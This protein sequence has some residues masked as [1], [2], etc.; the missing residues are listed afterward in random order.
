MFKDGEVGGIAGGCICWEVLLEVVLDVRR[1]EEARGR[2]DGGTEFKSG[3]MLENVCFNT[4]ERAVKEG[5]VES[6]RVKLIK[7]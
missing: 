4:V 3:A 6:R 7:E 1:G 2:G 5:V